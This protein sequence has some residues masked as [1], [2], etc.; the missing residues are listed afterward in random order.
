M[1]R[2]KEGGRVGKHEQ[3]T[4]TTTT[5]TT[6]E[7]DVC[8]LCRSELELTQTHTHV[9]T[10]RREGEGGS[11][12]R[13]SVQLSDR[14]RLYYYIILLQCRHGRKKKKKNRGQL[15]KRPSDEVTKK[16]NCSSGGSVETHPSCPVCKQQQGRTISCS[17][18]SIAAV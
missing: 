13:P 4:T 6:Q 1:R 14:A 17:V 7:R 12:V 5:T 18:E 15:T 2:K 16:A 11:T 9:G 8:I 3:Q 10:H